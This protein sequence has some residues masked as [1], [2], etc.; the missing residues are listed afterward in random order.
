M[1]IWYFPK[2]SPD[3]D[4]S[5]G[6][7]VLAVVIFGLLYYPPALLFGWEEPASD[8]TT[9]ALLLGLGIIAWLILIGGGI[10]FWRAPGPET[11]NCP[12]CN[13][14]L[15][16][17]APPAGQHVVCPNCMNPLQGTTSSAPITA[18]VPAPFGHTPRVGQCNDGIYTSPDGKQWPCSFCSPPVRAAGLDSAQWAAELAHWNEHINPLREN[19]AE[20]QASKRQP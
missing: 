5:L 18:A 17:I 11:M 13:T 1:H 20:V 14:L 15:N 16:D 8:P 10:A 4:G 2:K 12:T 3:S 19:P 9:H 7:I 6:P